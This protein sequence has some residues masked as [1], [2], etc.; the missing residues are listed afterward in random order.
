MAPIPTSEDIAASTA[1]QTD[2]LACAREYC[3]YGLL[4]CMSLPETHTSA[5]ETITNHQMS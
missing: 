1:M 5:L 2:N 3:M 4:S